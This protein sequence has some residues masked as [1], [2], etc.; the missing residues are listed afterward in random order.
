MK[1]D[2]FFLL[3]TCSS[4]LAQTSSLHLCSLMLSIVGFIGWIYCLIENFPFPFLLFFLGCLLL[5]NVVETYFSIRVGFDSSLLKQM[6]H[7][8]SEGLEL[9]KDIFEEVDSALHQLGLVKK[10]TE[11]T[12]RKA[13]DR[14][15]G[16]LALFKYQVLCV[17]SQLMVIIT[18]GIFAMILR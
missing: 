9:E 11:M 15:K 5:L 1:K 12:T 16:C 17:M 7:Q 10:N 18:M 2:D 13:T 14:V 6:I 4:F 3:Q 8:E